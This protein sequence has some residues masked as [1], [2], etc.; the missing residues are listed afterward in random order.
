[1]PGMHVP[2]STAWLADRV[3]KAATDIRSIPDS[4]FSADRVAAVLDE[5]A[6]ELDTVTTFPP[7]APMGVPS[8]PSSPDPTLLARLELSVAL[9]DVR[10]A[11]ERQPHEP[12]VYDLLELLQ[13]ALTAGGRLVRSAPAEPSWVE[14]DDVTCAPDLCPLAMVTHSH[15][16]GRV[17]WS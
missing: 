14:T 16:D 15:R 2:T 8:P 13:H 9:R 7:L 5:L 17:S 6:R 10:S 12:T 4:W 1:M 3:R 11:L